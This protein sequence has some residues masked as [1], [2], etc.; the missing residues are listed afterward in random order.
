M[1]KITFSVALQGGAA[2]DGFM[3]YEPGSMISGLVQIVPNEDVN[4][5]RAAVRL[6]WRTKG[7][8]DTNS[9]SLGETEIWQGN[10]QQGRP[11]QKDFS[12]QLPNQPWSYSGHYI[13]IVWEIFVFV[14]IPFA[15]DPKFVQPFVMR[16]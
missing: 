15:S 1:D 16:P 5:R 10:L 8:G 11:I 13:N 3:R 14:D 7:R 12:F 9:E 6:R 2:E 4:S